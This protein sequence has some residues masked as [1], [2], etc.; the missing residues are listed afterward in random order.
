MDITSEKRLSDAIRMRDNHLNNIKFM[1]REIEELYD[2]IVTI[3][4]QKRQHELWAQDN[5]KIIA[6]LSVSGES[7][8]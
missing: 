5:E 1:E 8:D 4:L 3:R 6:Q 2:K 7:R